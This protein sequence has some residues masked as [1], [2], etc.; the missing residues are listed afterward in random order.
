MWLEDMRQRGSISAMLEDK[1]LREL[2]ATVKIR[3]CQNENEEQRIVRL[4]DT[5][6]RVS[7]D[8]KMKMKNKEFCG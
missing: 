7:E 5:R 3:T 6:K 8:V 1:R 4:A 2:Q